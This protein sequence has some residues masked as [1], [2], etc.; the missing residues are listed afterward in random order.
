[1]FKLC[2][3]TDIHLD[4]LTDFTR[5]DKGFYT[6]DRHISKRKVESF[7]QAVN[8]MNSDALVI[9]GDITEAPLLKTHLEWLEEFIP[10]IPIYFVLGNHDY[11]KGSISSV[12]KWLETW[13]GKSGRVH[14]LNKAG[15]VRLTEKTALI[16]HDGWHDGGYGNWFEGHVGMPEYRQVDE[17]LGL[18]PTGIH[19]FL[20]ELSLQNADHILKHGTIGAQQYENLLIATHVPVFMENARNPQGKLSDNFWL[21]CFSSKHAGDALL[22]LAKQFPNTNFTCLSGHTHTEWEQ[23]YRKNLVELTG[24]SKYGTPELSIRLLDII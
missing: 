12:R 11:C 2:W 15:V 24:Y 21:P 19:G 7:C 14:W 20:Q 9:T 18:S 10:A 4:H 5:T 3:C 6:G 17:F 16:G 23:K 8:A 1:M 22:K 13:H